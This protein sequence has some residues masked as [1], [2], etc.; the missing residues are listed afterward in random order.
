LKEV[1]AE[2]KEELYADTESV[3]AKKVASISLDAMVVGRWSMRKERRG[4][5]GEEEDQ[6][7]SPTN[8]K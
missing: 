8:I 1:G 3:G 2:A 5:K 7:F 6:I 4:V